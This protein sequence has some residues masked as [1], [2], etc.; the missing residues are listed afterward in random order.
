[1]T[2]KQKCLSWFDIIA[3]RS[4]KLLNKNVSNTFGRPPSKLL[5]SEFPEAPKEAWILILHLIFNQNVTLR[6]YC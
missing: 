4:H 2:L 3:S 1:M 6:N 5:H